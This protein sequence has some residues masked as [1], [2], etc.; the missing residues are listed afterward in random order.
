MNFLFEDEPRHAPNLL[1]VLSISNTPKSCLY[2][3][4]LALLDDL[5]SSI[6]IDRSEG[7]NTRF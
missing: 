5:D 7:C 4:T 3:E 2:C 6:V 1:R